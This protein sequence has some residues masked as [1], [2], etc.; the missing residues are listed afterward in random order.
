[1]YLKRFIFSVDDG[2]GSASGSSGDDEDAVDE[3][4]DMDGGAKAKSS[5]PND[6][7]AFKMDDYDNEE[8]KG[9]GE[10]WF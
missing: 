3:D 4:I 7:S 8:S 1:M 5:D 2:E 6:L 9:V 10:C